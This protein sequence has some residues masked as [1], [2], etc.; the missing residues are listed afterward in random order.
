MSLWVASD[1][2][3]SRRRQPALRRSRER[4]SYLPGLRFANF[5]IPLWGRSWLNVAHED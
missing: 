3:S 2:L 1:A 4:E 5:G